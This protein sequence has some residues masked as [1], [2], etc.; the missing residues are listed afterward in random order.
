MDARCER[1]STHNQFTITVNENCWTSKF[2]GVDF[3]NSFI[4]GVSTVTSMYNA[5][6]TYIGSTTS[7]GVTTWTVNDGGTPCTAADVVQSSTLTC[8]P[9]PT[10]VDITDTSVAGDIYATFGYTATTKSW[11]SIK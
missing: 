11:V 1:D 6:C 10:R 4:W 9:K 7:G 8:S 3:G 5:A 2:K